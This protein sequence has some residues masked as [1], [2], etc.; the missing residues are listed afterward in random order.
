MK[1]FV[2]AVTTAAI[3]A[4]WSGMAAAAVNIDTGAGLATFASERI[5]PGAVLAGPAVDVQHAIGFGVSLDQDRYI[6]YE[7]TNATFATQVLN[8]AV[9]G[10]NIT[11]AVAQG[12][13]PNTSKVIMQITATANNN[14]DAILTFL[15][16]AIGAKV[17]S[18]AAPVQIKAS[19]FD[20]PA[21]AQAYV[22]SG[23]LTGLLYTT[24]VRT[25]ANIASGLEFATTQRTSTAAVATKFINF[26][27][28]PTLGGSD[29][30]VNPTLAIMGLP[31]FQDKAGVLN[32]ASG[33]LLFTEL[34][35]ASSLT[36]TSDIP[37]GLGSAAGISLE[38]TGTCA[39]PGGTI[40]GVIDITGTSVTFNTGTT[41]IPPTAQVCF[42]ADNTDAI[43]RQ[44]FTIAASLTAAVGA[45]TVAPMPLVLGNFIRDGVVLRAAFAETTGAIGMSSAVHLSN[46]SNSNAAYT[47]RCLRNVGSVAGTPGVVPAN[48]AIR[49]GLSS[50]MGCPS[51]GSL[52]GLEVTFEAPKG[53]VI[54]SIVRQNV[55]TGQASFDAM[56]GNV[57]PD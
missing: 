31:T 42:T 8:G 27:A 25:A 30:F 56:V 13:A 51:D 43:A 29:G 38:V 20:G 21:N 28:N 15:L 1:K 9:V 5:V 53:D 47:V 12:G 45:D 52:R 34:V 4:G 36:V 7:L 39:V 22:T 3:A 40:G 37:G 33:D 6:V 35:Q 55:T 57:V 32:E 11:S 54:G 10:A 46:V 2:L 19:L 18:D 41:P 49:H 50:G 44:T 16:G 17:T 24:G 14:P 26:K 48:T 23:S